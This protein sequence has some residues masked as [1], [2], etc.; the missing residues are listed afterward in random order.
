MNFRSAYSEVKPKPSPSGSRY[1]T[2]YTKSYENDGMP[3]L[4]EV[5]KED[6]YDSIQ[7]A[8]NG[9][10]LEDLIRRARSGDD[11]AIPEPIESYADISAMPSDMLSAHQMLL[12]AKDKYLR[13][14]A[15]V[16]SAFGNSFESFLAAASNGTLVEKLT[17]LNS[18]SVPDQLSSDEL[19]KVRS[20]IGGVNTDA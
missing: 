19:T 8:S 9:I 18:D 3:R 6:V 16:R 1:R 17:Q 13:L 7:K 14:P 20:L 11:S 12:D 2:T 4:I 5:G 10:L 15:D